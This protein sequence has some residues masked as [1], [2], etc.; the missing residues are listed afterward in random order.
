VAEREAG[1]DHHAPVVDVEVRAADA[2]GLHPDDRVVPRRQLGLGTILDP[3][4]SGRLEGDRLHAR[5]DAIGS[6][7]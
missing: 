5:L 4:L 3:D 2:G 7:P 1:L 6:R